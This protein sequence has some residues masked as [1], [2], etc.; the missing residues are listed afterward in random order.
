MAETPQTVPLDAIDRAILRLLARD[1]GTPL[2]AM[3]KL[4]GLSATPCWK[5][6][7]RMEEA[8]VILG[9]VAHL[10]AER[11]GYPVSVFVSVEAAD[12]STAWL[13]AFAE[14]VEAMPEIVGAWRMSGDIDYL[15]H[16]MTP[17]IPAY[18]NFY[19][20]LIAAVPLRNVTSRFAMER[21]KQ[22]PPP[23]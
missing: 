17:D 22:A 3:A 11:L 16:V 5:R 2:A 4:V 23:I 10:S 1:A 9:R 6:I 13:A 18:D 7:K 15:L 21:L 19:R 8:G 12:H 20:R 14:I